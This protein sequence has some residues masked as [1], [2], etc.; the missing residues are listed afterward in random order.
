MK[1]SKIL[2]FFL[3]LV[4][5]HGDC[6]RISVDT[7]VVLT[8][9]IRYD[10]PRDGVNNWHVR[11]KV[12]I[13]MLSSMNAEAQNKRDSAVNSGLL[14]F[15]IQEGLHHQVAYIDSCLTSY[16]YIGCGRDDGKEKGE[17]SALFYNT[18]ILSLQS[19]GTFWLSETPDIP[20]RGWDAALPR[21]C[22]YGLFEMKDTGKKLYVFNT[23]F[24]HIGEKAR[25]ESVKLIR[26]MAEKINFRRY[27]CI[28]MGDFNA[29]P[30]PFFSD[31]S[32]NEWL[33]SRLIALTR[34][35]P[36]G[37]FH[38]FGKEE[39]KRRIDYIFVKKMQV[40]QSAHLPDLRPDGGFLS[41]HLPVKAT[42]AF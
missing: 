10:E 27:P 24:D 16:S 19:S 12:V 33:D 25:Q 31:F 39:T 11:K 15:G 42:I 29:E 14:V 22:T 32:D 26:Y 30:G 3:V 34:T 17:Y 40:L 20:S 18:D 9:N 13:D 36:E 23:H 6:Q 5:S 2:V 4:N 28:I 1:F 21:I 7:H 37:T 41:D 38:G 35:G 8:Y